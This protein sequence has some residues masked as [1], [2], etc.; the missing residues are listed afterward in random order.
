M[1][2]F[3]FSIICSVCFSDWRINSAAFAANLSFTGLDLLP[4]TVTF[5][6]SFWQIQ[7][8]IIGG[9]ATSGVLLLYN[10]ARPQIKVY[11]SLLFSNLNACSSLSR[12]S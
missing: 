1:S 5:F 3:F 8:G 10:V 11:T 2:A 9:V 6:M 7:Y 12:S 4:F